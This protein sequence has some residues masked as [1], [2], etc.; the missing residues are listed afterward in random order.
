M[1]RKEYS[2]EEKA[3]VLAALLVGQSVSSVAKEYSI[4]KGTVSSWQKR[5]QEKLAVVRNDA[6]TQLNGGQ[7]QTEFGNKLARYMEASLDSLTSQVEVMGEKEYLRKQEMQQLAVGYGVQMDKF[8]RLLE[9]MNRD[10]SE[11][12][13]AEN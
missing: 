5:E 1:A 3:A 12:D 13:T 7:A 2:D 8:I 11:S 4:P 6:G 9:A 10:K